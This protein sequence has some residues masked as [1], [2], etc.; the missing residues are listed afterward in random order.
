[1]TKCGA[2]AENG[3]KSEIGDFG[4]SSYYTLG[5]RAIQL[6]LYRVRI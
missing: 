3:E 5:V 4:P 6:W 2:P 1:M